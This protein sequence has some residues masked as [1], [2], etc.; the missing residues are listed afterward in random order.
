VEVGDGDGESDADGGQGRF[1]EPKRTRQTGSE[2]GFLSAGAADFLRE[3]R[4]LR[5]GMRWHW[6]DAYVG[7]RKGQWSDGQANVI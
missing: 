2:G 5:D 4:G 3:R 7:G 1:H 6:I